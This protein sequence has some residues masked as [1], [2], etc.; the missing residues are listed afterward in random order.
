MIEF[1][2]Q[3]WHW[4]VAG[5]AFAVVVFLMT[6]LGRMFGISSIYRN[7]CAMA[8][9][10]K[11]YAYFDVNLKDE[12]WR[13]VFVLGIIVGG[14]LAAHYLASPGPVDISPKTVAHLHEWNIDA[15]EGDGF[16][17]V[18]LFNYSNWYGVLLAI[19]GGF[20]VGFGTRYADGCTSGH[21]I[22]GLS[23]LQVQ[24][25]IAVIGFFIGGLI[26]TWLILP[27]FIG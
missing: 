14:Y 27:L 5:V 7:F 26:M 6:W 8:G 17:P 16:L 15:T 20:L 2:S 4:A 3:P 10:G 9:A 19:I 11:K 21:A 12:R 23:H 1:I 24:S 13:L 22:T 18:S 25:L